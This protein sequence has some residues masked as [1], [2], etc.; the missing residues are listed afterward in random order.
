MR[1][2]AILLMLAGCT[3]SASRTASEFPDAASH[4][5]IHTLIA[6]STADFHEHGPAGPGRFRDVRSGYLLTA[7]GEPQYM[8]CGEFLQA[9]EDGTTRWMP[10]ATL[11]TSSYEQWIGAQSAT[12]CKAESTKWLKGDL[13]SALQSTLASLRTQR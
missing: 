9:Q 7:S 4:R 11:K 1:Y 10:F 12:F 6:Y 3:T 8:L 13:S 2:L 5:A